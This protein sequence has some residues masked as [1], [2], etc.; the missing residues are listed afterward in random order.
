MN[1]FINLI[2]LNNS[3]FYYL[4]SY[5]HVHALVKLYTCTCIGTCI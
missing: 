4:E 5:T 1:L 2:I 3:L